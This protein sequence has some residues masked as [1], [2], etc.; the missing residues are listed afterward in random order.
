MIATHGC[1]IPD[2]IVYSLLS[3]LKYFWYVLSNTI[4]HTNFFFFTIAIFVLQGAVQQLYSVQCDSLTITTDS[5]AQIQCL[6]VPAEEDGCG[7]SISLSSGLGL[8]VPEVSRSVWITVFVGLC[9]AT[10]VRQIT[11]YSIGVGD[12]KV[13]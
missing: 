6:T 2:S 7:E 8:A 1:H 12:D 13:G 3:C 4:S 10:K 11:S 5:L 9:L